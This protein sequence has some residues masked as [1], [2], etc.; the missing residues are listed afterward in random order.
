MM[1]DVLTADL[2]EEISQAAQSSGC[3]LWHADYKGGRLEVVLDRPEG[4]TLAN[5]EDVSRKISALLDVVDFAAS[6]YVLEVSSPG[7]DRRLYRPAD[8]RRFEGHS[9]RVTW[10]DSELG[11]RTD[12]GTLGVEADLE[13]EQPSIIHLTLENGSSIDI[14]FSAISEARLEIEP[15][16]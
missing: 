1:T 11:K 7:L 12:V 5:C 2:H 15:Q 9:A 8:Y 4:V 6:K 16:S 3:E 13:G 10:Q 14:P